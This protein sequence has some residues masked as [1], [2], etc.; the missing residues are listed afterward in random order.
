MYNENLNDLYKTCGYTFKN[1]DYLT[2]A[3]THSSYANENRK[4]KNE[5][6]ERLEFFGDS[7]MEFVVTEYI[8]KNSM[9]NEGKMT[10]IRAELVSKEPLLRIQDQ[11]VKLDKSIKSICDG[12][13]EKY[14]D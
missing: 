9:G 11:Y 12:T 8:Y 3:L 7:I 1:T 10:Q 6:N 4:T 14:I 2:L 5:C 13:I